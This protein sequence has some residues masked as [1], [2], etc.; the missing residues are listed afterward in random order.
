M[1]FTLKHYCCSLCGKDETKPVLTKQGFSIVQ[2]RHCGFVYVN[3]RIENEQLASIYR[4]NYFKNKDYGYA[5]YEQEK[6]LRIKNFERWLKDA[7]NY[8]AEKKP[9]YALDVGCAAGYCLALM[10]AKG[11]EATGLELDEEMYTGLKQIGYEVSKL[12][13]ENFESG[14]KFSVITLFDVIEH[15]PGISKAFS[16]LNSLL[17]DDGIII[18]VTPDYGSWQ[19]KLLGKRWFQFK[20]IEHI[21]YF[22]KH[23]LKMFAER[24][25]LKIVH[26]SACGQY[27]D[28]GFLLNRLNYYHFTFLARIFEKALRLL[29]LKN[30]FFYTDTG[31]LF[32]VL[33]HK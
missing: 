2:C 11:W 15:I 10:K 20:P 32:V 1:N 21:Q 30:R 12:M 13:L 26:Q 7:G 24:N 16:K 5:G 33:K 27:A 8:I 6:K 28:T 14:K 4:H 17:A 19:R 22:S 18:M 23:S 29:R 9:V 31:S 3:P 25:G